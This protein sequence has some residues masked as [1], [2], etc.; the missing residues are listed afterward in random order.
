MI[1]LSSFK[2]FIYF[3]TDLAVCVGSLGADSMVL[4]GADIYLDVE[5]N[6]IKRRE[7]NK[8]DKENKKDHQI[9]SFTLLLKNAKIGYMEHE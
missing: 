7:T 5:I 1:Q 4:K 9:E 3:Y 8:I 2:H 6:E